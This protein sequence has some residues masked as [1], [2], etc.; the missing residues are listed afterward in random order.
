MEGTAFAMAFN[1]QHLQLNEKQ[2]VLD[3]KIEAMIIHTKEVSGKPV[4]WPHNSHYLKKTPPILYTA[5]LQ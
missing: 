1:F 2:A 4:L 5:C 3:L